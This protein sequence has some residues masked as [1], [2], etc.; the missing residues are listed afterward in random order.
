MGFLSSFFGISSD[1]KEVEAF[2]KKGAV[3]ID[4]RTKAEYN[5]GHIAKSINIPLQEFKSRL[6]EIKK[7]ESPIIVCCKSGVRSAKAL[8]ILKQKGMDS[9][10]GGGW[11]KV[12]DLI[13]NK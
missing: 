10:N 4:V 3:V 13:N 6:N 8:S 11:K 2:L 12:D 5:Q 9:V 7:I 1:S